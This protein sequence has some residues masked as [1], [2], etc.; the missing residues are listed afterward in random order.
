MLFIFDQQ[1]VGSQEFQQYLNRGLAVAENQASNAFHCKTPDCTSFCFYDDN[2]NFFPCPVCNKQNCL[3]CK[4]IHEGMN[5]KEYQEDLLRRSA[6]DQA[7]KKTKL[8]LE[9]KFYFILNH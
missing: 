2:I 9:V 6:N 3:T 4:A 7:A 8:T 5:C 1:L